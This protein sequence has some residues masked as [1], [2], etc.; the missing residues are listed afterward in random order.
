[1]KKRW[2]FGGV[3]VVLLA[4][5]STGLA[6]NRTWL[7]GRWAVSRAST[8]L[9][10]KLQAID[11]VKRAT[12]VYDPVGLP[13]PTVS[14]NVAFTRSSPSTSWRRAS[15]MIRSAAA[16][17]DET[18]TTATF[19]QTGSRASAD[20]EP[21]AF[22]PKLVS[23]EIA[24]WRALGRSFGDRISLH[25]GHASGYS[26][27]SGQLVREYSVRTATDMRKIAAAWP[28]QTP[29]T[30][31]ALPTT[32]SGPGLQLSTMPSASTMTAV[33]ALSKVMPL[34]PTAKLRATD[35]GTYAAV[36]G[37]IRGFQVEILSL[38]NGKPAAAVPNQQLVD[39]T[40]IALASGA[41]QV[42]WMT[43]TGVPSISAGKC[44]TY[45]AGGRTV[46]TSFSTTDADE[47]FA[48]MLTS[49][50]LA[51]PAGVRGGVCS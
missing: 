49:A 2:V 10:S 33:T 34:A 17:L 40:R 36:I 44:G 27:S 22:S 23:S 35:T 24:G 11:G 31:P 32:W 38:R 1:M 15:G 43:S 6:V 30:D 25:L 41:A 4:V 3:V 42:D 7:E 9:A 12:A 48:S 45:Q 29:P 26:D 18:T 51:L 37:N 50:G 19:H 47:E 20:V 14:V 16:E 13:I 28:A 8:D 21:L 46:T 39:G 5:S